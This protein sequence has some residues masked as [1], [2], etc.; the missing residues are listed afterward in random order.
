MCNWNGNKRLE[1]SSGIHK[2]LEVCANWQRPNGCTEEN[3]PKKHRCS[4]CASSNHGA[5]ECPDGQ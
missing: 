5:E 4:G 1:F 2:G 3:H